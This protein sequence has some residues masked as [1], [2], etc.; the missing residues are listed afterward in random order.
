MNNKW[1]SLFYQLEINRQALFEKIDAIDDDL[2]KFKPDAHSWSIVQVCHHLIL[3]E[4]LSLQYLNKKLQYN[5]PIAQAGIWA[6]LRSSFINYALR[7][8][9]R[10]R[11]PKRVSEFPETLEWI[12]LKSRWVTVRIGMR[13]RLEKIPEE[14]LDKLVYKHPSIGRLTIDQMLTFFKNHIFR[15]EKQIDR[16]IFAG[17][18][19]EW[20]NC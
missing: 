4:E 3:S 20:G 11:A 15:H 13:E 6:F 9:I 1:H 10:Y 14:Y 19:L 18:E 12:D 2:V 5:S 8:P 16:L 17:H 7:F